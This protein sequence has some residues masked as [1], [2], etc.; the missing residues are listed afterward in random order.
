MSSDEPD[1]LIKALL[2]GESVP[3]PPETSGDF[4][5]SFGY[6]A[7]YH[8]VAALLHDRR[9]SQSNW[10]QK[11]S[12]ALR[13]EALGRGM[14]ELRHQ[15]VLTRLIAALA[16]RGVTPL[17]FKGTALAYDLYPN[18]VWRSRGDTD[19]L[20]AAEDIEAC[21]DVLVAQGFARGFALPGEVVSYEE[22]WTLR[23]SE[24]SAHSIDVHRRINNS[25]LLSQLF[26]YE[27]L[28]NVLPSPLVSVP[29][30]C[31]DRP[32]PCAAGRLYASGGA[33]AVPLLHRRHCPL[34]RRPLDLALRYS[35]PVE[36]PD[37]GRMETVSCIWRA[38]RDLP[39]HV[40]K[41]CSKQSRPS[42]RPRR[43]LS[44]RVLSVGATQRSRLRVSGIERGSTD[45]DEFPIDRG[46]VPKGGLS[47]GG[48]FS[49]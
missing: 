4:Q 47:Q 24:G 5:D 20:V 2:R 19:I 38:Q 16:E 49:P 8:G 44:C 35:S 32:C 15:H 43:S 31:R 23:A 22:T 37:R 30:G 29:A 41:V 48:R 25:E 10:P 36:D 14:W 17:L 9:S 21:R 46:I 3:W 33:Q 26:T 28:R 34:Q 40:L 6:R 11:V 7:R 18:P 42:D 27:E 12:D 39:E 1:K 13:L 45:V